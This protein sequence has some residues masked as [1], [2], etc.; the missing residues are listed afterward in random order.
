ME[1]G[2]YLLSAVVRAW[3][4]LSLLHMFSTIFLPLFR[5]RL[6]LSECVFDIDY[7]L[8]NSFTVLDCKGVVRSVFVS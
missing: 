3:F 6:I 1:L 4:F 8:T 7:H 5:R 2:V